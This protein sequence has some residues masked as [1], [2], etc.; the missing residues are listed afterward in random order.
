MLKLV[1]FL[2]GKYNFLFPLFTGSIYYALYLLDC[3][4]F[5][6]LPDFLTVIGLRFIFD[7][8]FLNILLS[9]NTI[10][11]TCGIFVPDQ[12]SN[13]EPLSGSTDSKTLDY[14]RTNPRE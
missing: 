8:S 12:R 2:T 4:H 11:T 6:L 1:L 9:F 13:P 10:Q 3:F 14:Q 5:A 7:L